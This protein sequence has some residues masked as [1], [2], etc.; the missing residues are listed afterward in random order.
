MQRTCT[1]TAAEPHGMHIKGP[2]MSRA[3]RPHDLPYDHYVTTAQAPPT[4]TTHT[5]RAPSN[6]LL[7]I[8]AESSSGEALC[9]A[10][11]LFRLWKVVWA[12]SV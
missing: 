6:Q 3:Q 9:S 12:D 4:T 8:R 1:C 5:S 10:L 11:L 7:S 2:Y